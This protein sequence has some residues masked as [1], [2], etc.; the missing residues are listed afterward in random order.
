M[1]LK[2]FLF[3]LLMLVLI[4]YIPFLGGYIDNN[5]VFPKDYFK[6]PPEGQ[7]KPGYNQ[8]AFLLIAAV[9]VLIVLVYVLPRLFGFKKSERLMFLSKEKVKLPLWFWIGL[10]VWA[11]ALIIQA[12]KFSEPKWFVNWSFIPLC[13]GF[14]LLL[15]GLVYYINGG[16]SMLKDSPTE[17]FGMAMVSISGW[18]IFEYL[19]FFIHHNWYYPFAEDLVA[20]DS[21]IVYAVIGSSAFIPMS[22]EWYQ[23]LRTSRLLD[24]RFR[25]GPKVRL[26]HW[27]KIAMLVISLAG[28]FITPFYPNELFWIVWLAPVVILGLALEILK[29]PTPFSEISRNRNW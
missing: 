29:I 13:W 14:I 12:G 24:H 7:P 3:L 6:F 15:D 21:F 5:G 4:L 26:P 27:L 23:L 25:K 11:A 2:P 20:H 28:M 1:R 18:F 9:F 8:L 17:L 10:V 16:R 22:F 19:N